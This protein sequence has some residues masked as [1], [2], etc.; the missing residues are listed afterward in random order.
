MDHVFPH[1]GTPMAVPI[2]CR[3]CDLL[4]M[5]T[6]PF[7]FPCVGRLSTVLAKRGLRWMDTKC[8]LARVPSGTGCKHVCDVH[9]CTT[10][11]SCNF[12]HNP[13]HTLTCRLGWPWQTLPCA[14][15]FITRRT[16][17]TWRLGRLLAWCEQ[18]VCATPYVLQLYF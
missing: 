12:I 11:W 7:A 3:L 1:T 17:I 14:P 16:R 5:R 13:A 4:L 8:P 6:H 9:S 18:P 2:S 15:S 10:S